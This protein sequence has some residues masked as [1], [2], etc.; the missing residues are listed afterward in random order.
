M[1]S[2]IL[3][4]E[5]D[6]LQM[7]S[8]LYIGDSHRGRRPGVLVFPEA[9][10]LGDHAKSKAKRLAEAGYVALACDIHGGGTILT[11]PGA[12]PSGLNSTAMCEPA[13]RSNT[14]CWSAIRAYHRA[15]PP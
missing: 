11:D 9:F 13:Q 12:T 2:E 6:G 15:A 5:A 7:E 4:Y 14:G 1:H 8:H 3:S 10:G